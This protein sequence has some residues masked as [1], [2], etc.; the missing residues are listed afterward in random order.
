[1]QRICRQH[2]KTVWSALQPLHAER[3]NLKQYGQ[4]RCSGVGAQRRLVHREQRT[5]EN[6]RRRRSGG[7]HQQ[8]VTQRNERERSLAGKVSREVKAPSGCL[9]I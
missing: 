7:E 4:D 6:S 9:T 2:S 1:L 5:E 3:G 8:H